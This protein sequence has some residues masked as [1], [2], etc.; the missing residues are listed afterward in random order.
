[1]LSTRDALK[2]REEDFAEQTEAYKNAFQTMGS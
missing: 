2:F 1:L